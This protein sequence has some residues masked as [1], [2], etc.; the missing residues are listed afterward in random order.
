MLTTL[1]KKAAIL[2]RPAGLIPVPFGR[3]TK[4]RVPARLEP[5]AIWSFGQMP[6]S[7]IMFPKKNQHSETF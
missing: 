1:Q 6:T 7:L 3:P 2:W 4:C 5:C